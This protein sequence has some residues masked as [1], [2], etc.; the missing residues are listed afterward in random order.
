MP[1]TLK[2]NGLRGPD[3]GRFQYSSLLGM[4]L[5]SI[6]DER[7]KFFVE[8][9]GCDRYDDIVVLIETKQKKDQQKKEQLTCIQCKYTTSANRRTIGLSDSIDCD[10]EKD[11][12]IPMY[13]Y[14][15][16]KIWV[17]NQYDVAKFVLHTNAVPA[18]DLDKYLTAEE[19]SLTAKLLKTYNSTIYKLTATPALEDELKVAFN[20]FFVNQVTLSINKETYG[21]INK[22]KKLILSNLCT[23]GTIT[24]SSLVDMFKQECK[25]LPFKMHIDKVVKR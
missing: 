20:R 21:Y 11:F 14:A 17:A 10:M 24:Y 7:Y 22:R 5:V 4:M 8:V 23:T 15:A 16:T 6:D 13:F 25:G 1:T 19:A 3:G 18:T 2:S 9:A 12:S